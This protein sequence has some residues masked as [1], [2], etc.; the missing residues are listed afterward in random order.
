MAA[1]HS[2]LRPLRVR[3]LES[4]GEA[5]SAAGVARRL[6]VPRQKVNYHLRALEKDGLLELV[7]ERKKGNCTE[8]IVKATARSYLVGAAALGAIAADPA[9]AKDRLSSAFLVSAMAGAVR[10]VA[11]MRE[12]AEKAK[13]S[14]ATFTLQTEVRFAGPAQRNAFAEELATFVARLAARY[15]DEGASRGRPFRLLA[16]IYPAPPSSE[17]THEQDEKP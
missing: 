4:L 14:L 10:D 12:R 2:L 8:R 16:G 6:E 9:A 7:E 11:V 3:I 1:T 5:D 13:K 15:H 17:A